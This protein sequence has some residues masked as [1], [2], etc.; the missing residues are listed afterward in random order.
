VNKTTIGEKRGSEVRTR[1]SE[2]RDDSACK[3]TGGEEVGQ[4][5]RARAVYKYGKTPIRSRGRTHA[6]PVHLRNQL[7]PKCVETQTY[8]NQ[9]PWNAN[10]HFL[11]P[12]SRLQ[13]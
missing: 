3:T 6:M 13:G 9:E 1:R 11:K 7:A 12:G 4:H 2:S 8:A 5:S 10:T